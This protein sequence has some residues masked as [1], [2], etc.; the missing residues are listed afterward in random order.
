MIKGVKSI[1]LSGLYTFFLL[2][3]CVVTVQSTRSLTIIA[4]FVWLDFINGGLTIF[5]AFFGKTKK[6]LT[7]F[8]PCIIITAYVVRQEQENGT[9]QQ[10]LRKEVTV[11]FNTMKFRE[12]AGIGIQVNKTIREITSAGREEDLR[13]LW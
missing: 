6:K 10:I 12:S 13:R 1:V 8:E 3:C 9:A 4:I 2:R 11:M 7:R 5:S